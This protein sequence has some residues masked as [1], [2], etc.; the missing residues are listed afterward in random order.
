MS[1]RESP[2]A[3][4]LPRSRRSAAAPWL[5]GAS[6]LV[7]T[8]NVKVAAAP[9]P[10]GPANGVMNPRGE[11]VLRAGDRDGAR[12]GSSVAGAAWSRVRMRHAP[13]PFSME[14][15]PVVPAAQSGVYGEPSWARADIVLL[16]TRARVRTALTTSWTAA[17]TSRGAS[18]WM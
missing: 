7:R 5:G 18:L 13:R 8:Q 11:A 16:S 3:C 10:L 14:S 2:F 6:R 15:R 17:T 4:I 9:P 12:R 1:H